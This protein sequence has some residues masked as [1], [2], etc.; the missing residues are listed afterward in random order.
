MHIIRSQFYQL[1]PSIKD[2]MKIT[3][4][5]TIYSTVARYYDM[6]KSLSHKNVHEGQDE[7]N[8]PVYNFTPQLQDI[9]TCG[10]A[11]PTKLYMTE[12]FLSEL[13]SMY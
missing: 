4:L 10:R 9:M 2:Q 12:I 6:W 13:R 5:S 11:C 7:N 3:V 1:D 8:R